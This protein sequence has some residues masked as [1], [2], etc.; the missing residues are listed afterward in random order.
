MAGHHRNEDLLD[1]LEARRGIVCAVGAGG[2]KSAL[3]RLMECHPGRA[4][5]TASAHTTFFPTTLGL[6]PIIEDS[7]TITASVIACDARKIAYASPS[8]RPGRHAGVPVGIIEE[9]HERGRFDA[10]LVK[11]DG[12]RMRL[13]KAPAEHEPVI[14]RATTTLVTVVSAAAIG[15]VFDEKIVHRL[16]E[17]AHVA[18]I[19][20]GDRI[21]PSHVARLLASP[22]GLLKGAG[23]ASVVPLINMV[24]D[25][26]LEQLA[27]EAAEMALALTSRFERVVLASL[28]RQNSALVA[29]VRR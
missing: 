14:P 1:A 19:R 8:T 21:E 22:A 24:D 23:H 18:G 20:T 11:A 28:R 26:A 13:L 17:T 25:A 5:L 3:Y 16:E 6:H 2:K 9:I 27:R 7:S 10:T 29:V 4:A 15:Q 12:A